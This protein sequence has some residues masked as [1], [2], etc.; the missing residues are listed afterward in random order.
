MIRLEKNKSWEKVCPT[1]ESYL[2]GKW[3]TAAFLILKNLSKNENGR[4][5]F[6]PI[7]ID[8]MLTYFIGLLTENNERNLR[9]QETELYNMNEIEMDKINLI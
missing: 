6:N 5:Y 2:G 9:D 8:K 3:S 1:V 4:Q 7:P